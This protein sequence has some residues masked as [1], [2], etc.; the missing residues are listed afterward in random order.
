MSDFNEIWTETCEIFRKIAL[1]VQQLNSLEYLRFQAPVKSI[2][3]HSAICEAIF[4][5][6][7][8]EYL[9]VDYL[10]S[11]IRWESRNE[12]IDLDYYCE[13]FKS[14]FDESWVEQL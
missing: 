8:L 13:A 1:Q 10:M 3:T 12:Q 6:P 4:E 2:L 5:K 11:K 14:L 7:Q 9:H